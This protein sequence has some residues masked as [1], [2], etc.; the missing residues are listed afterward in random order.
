MVEFGLS[1]PFPAF[2]CEMGTGKTKA[3]IDWVRNLAWQHNYTKVLVICPRSIMENWRTE[4]VT[5]SKVGVCVLTGSRKKRLRL[6]SLHVDTK[7]LLFYIINY[8]GARI[9]QEELRTFGFEIV[10]CDESTRIKNGTAKCTKA[11]IAIGRAAQRR[12][13]MSGTPVTQTLLDCYSQLLFLDNGISFGRSFFAFRNTY[14]APAVLQ[15]PKAHVLNKQRAPMHIKEVPGAGTAIYCPRCGA[16]YSTSNN[17]MKIW[18]WQPKPGASETIMQK[19]R[20]AALFLTKQEC[21]DLPPKIYERRIVELSKEEAVSYHQMEHEM[22]ALLKDKE[23]RAR[24]PLTQFLKLSQICSG[25]LNDEA[26]NPIEF[27]HPA[28]LEE[29]GELIQEI[30]EK[31][32]IWCRFKQNIRAVSRLLDKMNVRHVTYYSETE[33]KIEAEKD[34]REDPTCRI[35]IGQPQS[36]GYGLNFTAAS[37]VIYYSMG[38]SLTERL[39]SEDRVHRIGQTNKVTYVDIV[40]ENTIDEAILEAVGKKKDILDYVMNNWHRREGTEP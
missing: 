5:H 29:L 37:V 39:Q 40:A 15:C 34:F 26:G 7:T 10:I 20:K 14:F 1:V 2:F 35:L 9:L 38:Y 19:L 8:E 31:A 36:G 33:N 32:I 25:F 30:P 27:S 4:V 17:L 21:L 13:I 23:V 6:L 3:A 28:K 18:E 16:W 24:I 22:R 11:C 12:L